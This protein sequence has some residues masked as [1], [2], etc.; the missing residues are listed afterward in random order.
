LR[1][2]TYVILAYL[3]IA[4]QIGL[5]T[6][7]R[8]RGAEPNFVLLAALFIALNAP[9]DAALLGCFCLGVLQDL[10]T[11][12]PPGLFALS[13]GFTGML[14]VSA[15]QVV[16]RERALTHFAL[17]LIGG[18]L[19]AAVLLLHGWIHPDAARAAGPDGTTALNAIRLSPTTE[20]TRALYTA[21]LAPVV[22]GLLQRSRRS[23]AFQP[24]RRKIRPW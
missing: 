11:Q 6:F 9:R 15:H 1:W 13:Y 7:V 12:Q 8:Y 20:L 19:T 22:I 3:A 10:V 14:A 24:Q 4:V 21:L 18:M 2:F 5:G 17:A 23:F 16:Y